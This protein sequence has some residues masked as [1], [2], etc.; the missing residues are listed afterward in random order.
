MDNLGETSSIHNLWYHRLHNS[1]ISLFIKNSTKEETN[2]I[3]L[4]MGRGWWGQQ[5]P[6]LHTTTNWAVILQCNFHSSDGTKTSEFFTDSDWKM[7][8]SEIVYDDIYNGE[9]VDLSK[10]Q[11]DWKFSNFSD[12]HWKNAIAASNPLQYPIGVLSS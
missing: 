2:G 6:Q 10:Q 3:G 5:N 11:K 9:T 8:P 4:A 12:K 1:T 7:S